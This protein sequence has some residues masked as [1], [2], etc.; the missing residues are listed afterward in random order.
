MDSVQLRDLVPQHKHDLER[1]KAVI[2]LGYPGIAPILPEL[3]KWMQDL[4]WPV[5]QALEP[6]LASIGEPLI[7]EIRRVL[8]G[9]DVMWKVWLVECLVSRSPVVAA[10][11]TPE[12]EQ[13][14]RTEKDDEDSEYLREVAMDAL[15]ETDA[16][17]SE[18]L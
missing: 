8:Q 10:A 13:M 15:A 7:P 14:A 5:A 9:D 11:L 3:L 6:F 1:V 12:L 2:A 18:I 4:N 16:A 17:R